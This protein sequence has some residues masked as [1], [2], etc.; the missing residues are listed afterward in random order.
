MP[1]PEEEPLSPFVAQGP[2]L[3]YVSTSGPDT[4][5][6]VQRLDLG[7]VHDPRERAVCRALLHHALALLD[8]TEPTTRAGRAS[9]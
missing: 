1:L 9:V 8:A 2:A 5:Q 3:F 6:S 7:A 4:T